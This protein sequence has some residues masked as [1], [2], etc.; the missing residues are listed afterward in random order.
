M[1]QYSVF[2]GCLVSELELPDLRPA[3][4]GGKPRW[5]LRVSNSG[6]PAEATEPRGEMEIAPGLVIRL[7]NTAAGFR[8]DY[9][10]VGTYELSRDGGEIT[11][12]PAPAPQPEIARLLLLGQVFALAL[13]GDGLLCLHGSGVAIRGR[14]IAFL[15]PKLHGKSTL[16]L[17]LTAAGARLIADD[18][19]AIE[20]GLRPRVRP[21]VQSIRLL[22][23]AVQR[24]GTL[25][26]GTR[27]LEGGKGTITDFPRSMVAHKIVPFAAAYLMQPVK[28]P[29]GEPAVRRQRLPLRDA[30]I[31]LAYGT[32]LPDPLVGCRTAGIDLQRAAAVARQVPVFRLEFAG[33]FSRLPEVAVQIL[34]WHRVPSRPRRNIVMA[35]HP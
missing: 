34:A 14:G 25:C 29:P 30:A 31:A 5:V 22:T 9:A 24:V 26:V 16:A 32:K 7:A 8:F 13:H 3:S 19:V 17:A 2:G 18:L 35:A 1:Y 20:P 15:A 21:G 6:S 10:P 33:D 23:D 27:I 11:W 12:Y 28:V 4:S